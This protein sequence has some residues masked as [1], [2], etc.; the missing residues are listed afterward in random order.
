[1]H[2]LLLLLSLKNFRLLA[3]FSMA[4]SYWETIFRSNIF[5]MCYN[6]YYEPADI[7]LASADLSRATDAEV[8][9]AQ[10]SNC[11]GSNVSPRKNS[12]VVVELRAPGGTG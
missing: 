6:Y 7:L 9:R 3:S 2:L 11:M 1:M 8:G 10:A 4:E 5:D 12:S